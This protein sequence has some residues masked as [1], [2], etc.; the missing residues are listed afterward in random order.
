MN[1]LGSL[2]KLGICGI[3]VG[4][5]IKMVLET[6]ILTCGTAFIHFKI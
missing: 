1:I 5:F 2:T 4:F 3:C 6:L